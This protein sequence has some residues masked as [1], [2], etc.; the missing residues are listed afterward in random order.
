MVNKDKL[1]PKLLLITVFLDFVNN[2]LIVYFN[3]ANIIVFVYILCFFAF[4]HIFTLMARLTLVL[5]I[6]AT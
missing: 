1:L 2:V 3:C 4:C 5:L 6:K